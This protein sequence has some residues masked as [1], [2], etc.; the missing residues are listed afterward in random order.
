MDL[1]KT[2]RDGQPAELE[3]VALAEA[4]AFNGT[5]S[6][7]TVYDDKLPMSI[8]NAK[9]VGGATAGWMHHVVAQVAALLLETNAK[10]GI[11]RRLGL[12][13]IE[14]ERWDCVVERKRTVYLC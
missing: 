14:K 12:Y 10:T 3:F 1:N 6:S 8:Q 7:E 13:V 4:E 11:S 5:H 2:W 9:G